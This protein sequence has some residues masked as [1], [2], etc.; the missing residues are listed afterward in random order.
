MNHLDESPRRREE[1]S[2]RHLMSTLIRIQFRRVTLTLKNPQSWR[3]GGDISRLQDVIRLGNPDDRLMPLETAWKR[4]SELFHCSPRAHFKLFPP[5]LSPSHIRVGVMRLILHVRKSVCHNVIFPDVDKYLCARNLVSLSTGV[6]FAQAPPFPVALR[7]RLDIQGN[8]A[9]YFQVQRVEH[10]QTVWVWWMKRVLRTNPGEPQFPGRPQ[11]II[12]KK[13]GHIIITRVLFLTVLQ[14][15]VR[16][17]SPTAAA[18]R[19]D[20]NTGRKRGTAL[21][22]PCL[23]QHAYRRLIGQRTCW[24]ALSES[25]R[26]TRACT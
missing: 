8:R 11:R 2:T 19:A 24:V 7:L 3:D 13:S 6:I 9:A 22:P 5:F 17:Q 20:P 21:L 26:E 15:D 1:K 25:V 12:K 23:H 10:D 14:F 16:H 18:R 4:R